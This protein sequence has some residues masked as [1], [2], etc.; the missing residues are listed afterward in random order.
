MKLQF[1]ITHFELF[2]F[3]TC[4]KNKKLKKTQILQK[5]NKNKSGSEMTKRKKKK[6]EIKIEHGV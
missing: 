5:K 2:I 3:Q 1:V 6:R 4:L